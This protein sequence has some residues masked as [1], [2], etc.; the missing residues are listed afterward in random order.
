MYGRG[1]YS[2]NGCARRRLFISQEYWVYSKNHHEFLVSGQMV[3]S[4]PIGYFCT[5]WGLRELATINITGYSEI[6]CLMDTSVTSSSQGLLP[7]KAGE[8]ELNA[9]PSRWQM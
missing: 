9:L 7:W 2:R 4:N 5:R 8:G 6:R 1:N 3:V